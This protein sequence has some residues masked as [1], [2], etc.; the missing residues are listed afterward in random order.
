MD[1]EISD[2]PRHALKGALPSVRSRRWPCPLLC[3]TDEMSRN[4][5]FGRKFRQIKQGCSIHRGILGS[6]LFLELFEKA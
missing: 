4:A 5:Q 1:F 2:S 6:K 3:D